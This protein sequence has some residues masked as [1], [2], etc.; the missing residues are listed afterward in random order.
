VTVHSPPNQQV[1]GKIIR[2]SLVDLFVE[3]NKSETAPSTEQK[4]EPE[5][6]LGSGLESVL[7]HGAIIVTR[8]IEWGSVILGYG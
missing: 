8:S 4:A 6:I 7:N 1:G 5:I 2:G 3:A